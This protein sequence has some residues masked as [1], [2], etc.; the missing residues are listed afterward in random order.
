MFLLRAGASPDAPPSISDCCGRIL[1]IPAFR[2]PMGSGAPL[3]PP[4]PFSPLGCGGSPEPP[5]SDSPWGGAG[6]PFSQSPAAGAP[7]GPPLGVP[8]WGPVFRPGGFPFPVTHAGPKS[9]DPP[10]DDL[11]GWEGGMPEG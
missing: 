4:F 3:S 7:P 5:L 6:D 2:F 1:L 10:L 9:G 8:R 11:R